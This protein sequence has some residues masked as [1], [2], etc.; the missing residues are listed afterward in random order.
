MFVGTIFCAAIAVADTPPST[1]PTVTTVERDTTK[2]AAKESAQKKE[3]VEIKQS[4]VVKDPVLSINKITFAAPELRKK[5]LDKLAQAVAAVEDRGGKPLDRQQ[6]DKKWKMR[7]DKLKTD[8]DPQRSNKAYRHRLCLRRWKHCYKWDARWI[9]KRYTIAEAA[10]SAQEHTGVD[11]TFLIAVGRMESDFRNLTLINTACKYGL[12]K[13]SCFADC[14]MTQHH[15]R[16]SMK[17]VTAYCK[18]L[19]RSPK[20]SFR[21]SAEEFARHITYCTDATRTKWHSPIRRCI[22]NRY[23][24]G[25]FYRRSEKC[26]KCWISPKH[27]ASRESYRQVLIAC[28]QRRRKCRNKAAYWKKVTCFEYGARHN[29]RS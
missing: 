13:H 8:A 25:P 16:G 5:H 7:C 29:T 23:N 19:A 17:Y 18:K 24:Q 20:L 2:A 3:G 9:K 21:K 27:F 14:G 4:V 11:A 10:L 28:Q 6:C 12:R 22:M 15:V 1:A 26:S